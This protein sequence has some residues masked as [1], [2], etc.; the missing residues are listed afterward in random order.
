MGLLLLISRYVIL[1][2]LLVIPLYAFIKKVPV[3]EV[4]V[5]GAAEGLGT[6]IRILPFL[7]GMLVAISV[8][9]ASGAFDFLLAC[10]Q[11]ITAL[12]GIP[13]EV[14]PLALMRPLSGGGAL[15]I[16]A[17]L[18]K[19]HG[20]DSFIGRLASIMQGSTDTTFYILAVYFG[21]VNIV[22]YRY[23]LFVG[24]AADG[25]SFL[26]AFLFCRWFFA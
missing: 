8:L 11:P 7:L 24:L 16:T 3:F 25:V 26:A 12:L 14:L 22:K 2:L 13:A 18:I 15:G 23:A 9:R 10:L 1:V 20:P 4:F 6:A 21:S 17:D 19:T 5:Q